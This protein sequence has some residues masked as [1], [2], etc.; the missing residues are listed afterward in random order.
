MTKILILVEKN[1]KKVK[2]TLIIAGR[3]EK[4]SNIV[5]KMRGVLIHGQKKE[6]KGLGF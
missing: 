2:L 4:L 3:C 5:V 6:S 1:M